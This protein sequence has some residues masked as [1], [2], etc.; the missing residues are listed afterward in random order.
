LIIPSDG[1]QQQV[2]NEVERLISM[3]RKKDVDEVELKRLDDCFD[4]IY[5]VKSA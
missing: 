1:K 5:D 2:V 3:A 4:E